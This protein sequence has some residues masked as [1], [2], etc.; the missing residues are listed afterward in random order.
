MNYISMDFS[1]SR[2]SMRCLIMILPVLLCP[3]YIESVIA[4]ITI[5]LFASEIT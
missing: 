4:Y 1:D 2:M 3:W 5:T